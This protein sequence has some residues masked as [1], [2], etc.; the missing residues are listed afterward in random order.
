MNHGCALSAVCHQ[1]PVASLTFHHA[2]LQHMRQVIQSWRKQRKRMCIKWTNKQTIWLLTAFLLLLGNI[3]SSPGPKYM[4]HLCVVYSSEVRVLGIKCLRLLQNS[5]HMLP[6]FDFTHRFTS[7]LLLIWQTSKLQE[8]T[9]LIFAC[10]MPFSGSVKLFFF[11]I[12]PTSDPK[13]KY[14]SSFR[15]FICCTPQAVRIQLTVLSS[16]EPVCRSSAGYLSQMA[17]KSIV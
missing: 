11:Q 4:E 15:L 14:R 13:K 9:E 7:S 6:T 3:H 8:V 17:T 5:R 10:M 1:C 12:V 2:G 16:L